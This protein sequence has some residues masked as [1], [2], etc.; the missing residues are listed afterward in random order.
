MPGMI[1]LLN[2]VHP[3]EPINIEIRV[4]TIECMGYLMNSIRNQKELF[5]TDANHVMELLIKII[6]SDIKEDDRHLCPVIIVFSQLADCM[7][8]NFSAY[9]DSVFPQIMK[10]VSLEI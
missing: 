1:N 7:K 5:N 3:T 9:M 4:L 2:T 10:A 8:E 6:S